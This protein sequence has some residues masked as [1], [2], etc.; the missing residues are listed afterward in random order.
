[1]NM[2]SI[3]LFSKKLPREGKAWCKDMFGVL[4][5]CII[6]GIGRHGVLGGLGFAVGC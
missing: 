1:M 2:K 6:F 4:W 3:T 5:R